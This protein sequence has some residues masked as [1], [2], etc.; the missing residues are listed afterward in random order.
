MLYSLVCPPP[1]KMVL[2]GMD[3]DGKKPK[4]QPN[5]L[6]QRERDS[7]NWTLQDVADKLYVM[8]VKEKRESGIS[9]DTVG[10]WERGVC[11]PEAHYRAKLCDLFGKN[12]RQLGFTDQTLSDEV[13]S[14]DDRQEGTFQ[15]AG[16]PHE[17]PAMQPTTSI[18][19]HEHQPIQLYLP[20]GL[21][22]VVTVQIYQQNESGT[23][24]QVDDQPYITTYLDHEGTTL[25]IPESEG[26]SVNRRDFLRETRRVA[27]GV[28]GAELLE[29]F[30]RALKKPSTLDDRFLNYLQF[31]TEDYWRDHYYASLASYDLFGYAREHFQKIVQLLEGPML[32]AIRTRLCSIAGGAALLIGALLFDMADYKGSRE[33]FGAA[34]KAAH[35][36]CQR[37]GRS[38]PGA[39]GPLDRQIHREAEHHPLRRAASC[40]RT[41]SVIAF[42]GAHWRA[43]VREDLYHQDHCGVVASHG[44]VHPAGSPN[45]TRC[46]ETCRNDEM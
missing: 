24:V 23:S 2:S 33:Y 21:P 25:P 5:S 37:T 27:L 28:M 15:V 41:G 39:G 20:N 10:R 31:H 38:G 19:L 45:W 46:P 32:P 6:L 11:R 12:A 17:Y 26:K 3:S 13:P 30:Y 1:S 22:H 14:A 7:R 4:P 8:C 9:A 44:E 43:W 18:D 35:C 34:I 42:A 16:I 40:G 29:R 36:V